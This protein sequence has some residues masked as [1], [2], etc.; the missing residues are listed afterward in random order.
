MPGYF[1]ISLPA[2]NSTYTKDS[3]IK[4]LNDAANRSRTMSYLSYFFFSFE[5]LDVVL[6]GSRSPDKA[7]IAIVKIN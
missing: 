1:A 2:G 6:I 3:I 7:G 4:E 5:I